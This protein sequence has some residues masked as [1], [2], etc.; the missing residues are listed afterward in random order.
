MRSF[1]LYDFPAGNDAAD[2]GISGKSKKSE[3]EKGGTAM[4]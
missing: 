3:D 4:L 1:D 2:T